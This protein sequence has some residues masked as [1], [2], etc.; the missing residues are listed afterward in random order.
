M[1]YK[2]LRDFVASLERAG[3]LRRVAAG[4]DWQYEV[5]GWIYYADDVRKHTRMGMLPMAHISHHF[6]QRQ[7]KWHPR[8]LAVVIGADETVTG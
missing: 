1:D 3:E 6:R 4:V 8:E 2:D 7:R 5:R